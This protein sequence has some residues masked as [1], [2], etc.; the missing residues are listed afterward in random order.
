L[1]TNSEHIQFF[2][3]STDNTLL[4]QGTPRLPYTFN[5]KKPTTLIDILT[6]IKVDESTRLCSFDIDNTYTNIPIIDIKN[7][8]NKILN[9]NAV[10]VI[11][12]E[13]ILNL[14]NVELERNYIPVN[15][16]YYAQ[17]EGLAT[18]SLTS[19]TL[20]EVYIYIYNT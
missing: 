16:Q 9:R 3:V 1:Q 15:E 4:L 10:K 18:G 19:A 7:T 13:E 17:N 8:I 6:S 2:T 12:K 11:V 5:I 20:A 14:L